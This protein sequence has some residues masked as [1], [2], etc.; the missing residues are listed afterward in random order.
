MFK[1]VQSISIRDES[2]S[3]LL[4][5]CRKSFREHLQHWDQLRPP[6]RGHVVFGFDALRKDHEGSADAMQICYQ[7]Q[8]L[9]CSW[10]CLFPLK[11]SQDIYGLLIFFWRVLSVT[12]G[13]QPFLHS[14]SEFGCWGAFS[15]QPAS[16]SGPRKNHLISCSF[17]ETQNSQT[18][19]L[20]NSIQ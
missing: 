17:E 6:L 8:F 7:I 10:H 16:Q 18:L 13:Q 14:K 1:I 12:G 9:A 2:Q 11:T 15:H 3:N 4:Q 20:I 19:E 5:M